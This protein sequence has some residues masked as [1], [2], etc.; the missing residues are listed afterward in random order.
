MNPQQWTAVD[1]YLCETLV[2]YDPALA[3][4]LKASDQA[5]LRPINVAPNQGKFLQLL[6]RIRG[7]RRILEI[8][9]LGGYSTIW[10]ARALPED[11]ALVSLEIDPDSAA[12]ARRNIAAAG[13]S[14]RV[15]VL[16]GPAAATLEHLAAQQAEP[17]DFVFIDADKQSTPDY[18][19]WS[20]K[21]ARPGTVIVTDNV[22][23]SGR[24][25][26]THDQDPDVAGVRGFFAA[27]AADPHLSTTA[28]QTVGSKGW[29]GFA[30]SVVEA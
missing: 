26:D 15:T 16:V 27:A 30:I 2:G 20:L 12:V 23:R 8:G 9:T 11:G 14:E 24:V 1:D 5:G 7:A 17:F 19:R 25:A 18:L 29:D 3:A 21:L 28:L 22:V 6:A 4:T 13:L 10:L